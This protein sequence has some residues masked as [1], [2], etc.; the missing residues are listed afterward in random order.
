[1]LEGEGESGIEVR[2]GVLSIEGDVEDKCPVWY[3]QFRK[4]GTSVREL[5]VHRC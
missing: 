1:V 5:H 2:E 3:D 4:L